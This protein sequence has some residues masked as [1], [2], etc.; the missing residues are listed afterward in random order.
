M[1]TIIDHN[2]AKIISNM[3]LLSL[4]CI[5]LAFPCIAIETVVIDP[6][7]PSENG[8][9]AKSPRGFQEIDINWQ[10][11]CRI[12]S[13]LDTGNHL[14]V[15][16][17]KSSSAEKVTN[18]CRAEIANAVSASLMLRIHCDS[19]HGHG[20]TLYYP[21]CPGSLGNDHGPTPGICSA[22]AIIASRLQTTLSR[23]LGARF[24][25]NPLRTDL[26]T[27]IGSRQGALTGSIYSKVP[28]VTIEL[29]Y[30]DNPVDESFLTAS[31][32]QHI[33]AEALS[34]SIG[35]SLRGLSGPI[36]SPRK[37]QSFPLQENRHE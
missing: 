28:V 11:A 15:I 4:L 29:G 22:S 24:R 20:A 13:L 19:G 5:L 2:R 21:S 27:A 8:I 36:V 18:R 7:H 9:G 23:F 25:V 14:R 37:D 1:P 31:E 3:S 34:T 6:G 33:L 32:T 10:V 30:F 12:R 16:L 26:Q 35:E 17:T